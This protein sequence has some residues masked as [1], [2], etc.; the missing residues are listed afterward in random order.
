MSKLENYE[1]IIWD[2]DG[3]I[4]DSVLSKSNSYVLLFDSQPIAIKKQIQEHHEK[5]GGISRFNKIP[6]YLSWV[7]D[8]VNQKLIDF[9][10]EKFHLIN[11]E[12]VCQCPYING[13]LNFFKNKCSKKNNILISA[14][15]TF[16]LKKILNTLNIEYHF[17]SVF[18]SPVNKLEVVKNLKINYK[19][20][21]YFGDS[22][23]DY[24]AAYNNDVDFILV[25]HSYNQELQDICDTKI[26]SFN[27]L[28]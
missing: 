23:E 4:L 26:E 13:Y 15:P 6:L 10:L 21:L 17:D 18:G 25:S 24:K 11:F 2:F 5:N 14:T 12:A 20:I 1:T 22:F 16:E 27:E 9:Y 19:N 8:D 28:L 7:Y 3:V